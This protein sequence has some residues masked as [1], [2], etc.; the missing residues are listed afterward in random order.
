MNVMAFKEPGEVTST[1]WGIHPE[2]LY[3]IIKY[4]YDNYDVKGGIY[5]FENGI[6]TD[7]D[8]QRIKFISDHL[9]EIVKAMKDGYNVKGYY[10]WT[11]MSNFEWEKG[12]TVDFG[13]IKWNIK[14]QERTIKD[15]AIYYGKYI[16]G[17]L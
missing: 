11:L 16:N 13:L 17:E 7:D 6:A 1:G 3:K 8:N 2:G 10:H 14:T 5:I 9:G 4:C 12:Y 15:S